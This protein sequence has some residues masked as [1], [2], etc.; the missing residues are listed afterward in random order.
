MKEKLSLEIKILFF[1]KIDNYY[2]FNVKNLILFE[3]LFI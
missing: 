3:F 1:K 2:K